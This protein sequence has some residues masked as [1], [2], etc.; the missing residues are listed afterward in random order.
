MKSLFTRLSGLTLVLVALALVAAACGTGI[1]ER[2][3][4]LTGATKSQI[5]KVANITDST[6]PYE[7]INVAIVEYMINN[8]F[9]YH[10]EKV[11]VTTAGLQAA[12]ANGTVHLAMEVP[13]TESW[14]G[15][16]GT[17][18]YGVLYTTADG[19][20]IHKVANPGLATLTP[21]FDASIRKMNV[22]ERRYA[23]TVQW[24][25]RNSVTDPEKVGVYFYWEFDFTDGSFKDWMEF[26]PWQDIRT[27]TQNVTRLIRGT[28]YNGADLFKD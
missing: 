14:I 5:V 24:I 26:D 3:T 9:H 17:V 4:G 11:D 2:G 13:G 10:V 12:L 6:S 20:E 16:G 19:V 18:D 8:G 25:A 23:Q 22:P 15:S 21:D 7:D 1:P 28:P 27:Y